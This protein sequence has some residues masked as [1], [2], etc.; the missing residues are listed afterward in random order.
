MRFPKKSFA[1]STLWKG[2]V[3]LI[4]YKKR[5]F[6]NS[7]KTVNFVSI[8]FN[9]SK[10]RMNKKLGKES[11]STTKFWKS[12][13]CWL[14]HSYW[15]GNTKPRINSACQCRVIFLLSTRVKHE[16]AFQMLVV[17]WVT[18]DLITIFI[19]AYNITEVVI[20][21]KALTKKLPLLLLK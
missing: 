14:F 17:E 4:G 18:Q 20:L 21:K 9:Y 5:I 3:R 12:L 13:Y 2:L 16:V 10:W 8:T 7:R 19:E 1:L 15:I 11:S 6:C